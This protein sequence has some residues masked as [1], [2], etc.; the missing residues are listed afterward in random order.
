M[1]PIAFKVKWTGVSAQKGEGES[2]YDYWLEVWHG[3]QCQLP[4]KG[5]LP[6][7]LSLFANK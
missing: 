5:S 1:D 2:E 6:F 4:C 7:T 3:K